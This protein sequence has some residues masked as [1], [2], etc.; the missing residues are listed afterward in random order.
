MK[1]TF[2]VLGAAILLSPAVMAATYSYVDAQ[3]MVRSTQADS[4]AQALTVSNIHPRSG[5]AIES[6]AMI[7]G[8]VDA[9]NPDESMYAYVDTTGTIRMVSADSAAEALMTSGIH[10]H[11][12]VAANANVNVGADVPGM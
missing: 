10:P 4:A 8:S 2:A 3:G 6:G 1:T 12:G 5:V 11:S 9:T 7:G